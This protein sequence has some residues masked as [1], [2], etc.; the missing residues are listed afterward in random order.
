MHAVKGERAG[1]FCRYSAQPPRS[2]SSLAWGRGRSAPSIF[3]HRAYAASSVHFLVG[4]AGVFVIDTTETTQAA[5]NIFADFRKISDL[6]VTT[7]LYTHSHRGHISG[8]TMFA[9]GRDVEVISS[10][11]FA[12]DL[13]EAD[14]TRP[15]P[16]AALM[17]RTLRF[18]ETTQITREGFDLELAK[19]PSGTHD[20]LIVWYA[21]KRV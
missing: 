6:P 18:A 9:Q 2:T 10:D 8:A 3:Q 5:E 16:N 15:A 12:L 21:E 17:A 13:V 1:G 14:D 20:H 11:N 4:Q 7:I 19:A